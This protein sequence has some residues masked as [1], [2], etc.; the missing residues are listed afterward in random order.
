MTREDQPFYKNIYDS[1]LEEI[2][3]GKLRPGDRV[4]SE[5]ELCGQFSVSRITSKRALELLTEQGYI[6]RFPGRG[7]FV[8]KKPRETGNPARE[9]RAIGFVIS[10]FSD[11]FGT[12]LLFSIEEA[13][14]ERGYYLILKRSMDSVE[15]EARAIASLTALGVDGLLVLPIHGEYYNEEILKLILAKKPLAFVD[16]KMRGLSAPS[17]STDNIA[18]ARQGAEYLLSLGHRNIG[19]YSGPIKNTSTVEDRRHGFI[20]AYAGNSIPINEQLF[21]TSLIS[22]WTYPFSDR[23]HV[24]QDI[25]RVKAHLLAH[26]EI[27]AAFSAEYNMALIINAAAEQLGRRVPGDLSILTFDSFPSITGKSRFTHLRQDEER[28]GRKAV[29]ILDAMIAGRAGEGVPADSM[30]GDA[31]FPAALIPGLSTGALDGARGEARGGAPPG[32]S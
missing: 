28:I 9:N 8:A 23:E 11:N 12:R 27:S 31:V 22:S 17:F 24:I 13:C 18:A 32:Q 10:D 26:P 7:S 29:E 16:R 19:F 30:L 1:L 2:K 25:E 3:A 5:K 14:R 6:T 21:C 20:D 4:P 15:E